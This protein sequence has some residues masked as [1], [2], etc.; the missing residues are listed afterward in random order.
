M[1]ITQRSMPLAEFLGLP[2]VRPVPRTRSGPQKFAPPTRG[3]RVVPSVTNAPPYLR[4]RG[5]FAWEVRAWWH[6]TGG[7]SVTPTS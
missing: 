1:A 3:G 2:E 6:K 4:C 7:R 5:A